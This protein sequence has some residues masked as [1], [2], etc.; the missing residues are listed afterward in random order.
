M[1]ILKIALTCLAA[2]VINTASA[3]T[4]AE[5]LSYQHR[6]FDIEL[7]QGDVLSV[8][9]K[10]LR[11]PILRSAEWYYYALYCSTSVSSE[12]EYS[13]H[14]QL[15]TERLPVLLSYQ[16]DGQTVGLDMD[17]NGV[18]RIKNISNEPEYI[19]CTLGNKF[20]N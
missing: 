20:G 1:K 18:F 16:G 5:N 4:L 7:K 19:H 14:G 3:A 17:E 10:L 9:Y 11:H 2:G 6:S 8:Q 15:N 12:M 13:S